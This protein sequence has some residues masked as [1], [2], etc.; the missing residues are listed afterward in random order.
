MKDDTGDVSALMASVRAEVVMATYS[1]SVLAGTILVLGNVARNLHLGNPLNPSTFGLF[2]IILTSYFLRHRIGAKW[3]AWI[4][5][6]ALYLG[7][8][9]GYFIYGFVGNS[10]PLYMGLCIVAAAF[11]G[12]RGGIIAILASA[13][14]MSIVAALAISGPLAISFD[15]AAFVGS[16][17]SW[18]A[19]IATFVATGI[20]VLTQAGLMNRKL[21]DLLGEQQVRMRD[22]A[23]AEAEIRRLN[24]DLELRVAARTTELEAANRSLMAA[25]LQ[26]EAANVAKSAFLANMSHEIRTPMNGILGMA[27]LLRRGGV[28]PQQADRLEKIDTAAQHLLGIIDNVLDISKIEAGKFALEDNRVA[29][30]AVLN[31]VAAILAERARAKG[32]G[33]L[34]EAGTIPPLLGDAARLQQALLNY[35]ANAIK[36]TERGTVTLRVRLLEQSDDT[37]LI[38][39]EVQDTGIG[40]AP[41]AL[42]KLFGAFE[43]ADNSTTRKYGGTGLGLAI[44]RRLAE[45]M[46]GDAGCESVPGTGSTFWFTARL[47]VGSRSAAYPP[48]ETVDAEAALRKRHAG[49][50]ILVVDDESLNREIALIQIEGADMVADQAEDGAQ[51]IAMAGSTAY[52]AILMDMQMPNVDGLAATRQIRQ[53]AGY[54]SIPIIALT[55]NAFAEDKARCIESGM[56]SVLVK[57]LHPDVLAATLLKHLDG[58]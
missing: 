52:A 2:A 54:Q 3:L 7:A 12:R 38:R 26:A 42:P 35:V 33:L 14:T 41:E 11:Y 46:G 53:L 18:I 16:P 32:I 20:L 57:P 49:R 27:H 15:M 47:K 31:N 1:A 22:M 29:I 10:A 19:A 21:Q 45:L 48:T 43:Q 6:A 56:N 24:A 9:I 58:G 55:A 34:I 28:T 25:K 50:R 39:F 23:T 8:T 17:F 37:A 30:D 40:I 5:L 13:L 51:A 4:L 44:T 36:F